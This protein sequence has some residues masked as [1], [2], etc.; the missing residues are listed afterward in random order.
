MTS[1][2]SDTPRPMRLSFE[3]HQA[4]QD[5]EIAFEF[6]RTLHERVYREGAEQEADLGRAIVNL[7][8]AHAAWRRAV[9]SL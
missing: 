3:A 7:Q 9:L 5:Y 8:I 1:D 4:F 2:E 6:Y